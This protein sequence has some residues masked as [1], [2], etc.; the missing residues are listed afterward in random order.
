M[1][2]TIRE[3]LMK[4]MVDHFILFRM[5]RPKGLLRPAPARAQERGRTA[6]QVGCEGV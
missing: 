2:F 6:L 1:S 3:M 4:T 5:E